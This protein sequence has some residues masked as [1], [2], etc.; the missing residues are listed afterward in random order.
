VERSDIS[1]VRTYCSLFIGWNGDLTQAEEHLRR[2]AFRFTEYVDNETPARQAM[3]ARLKSK[4]LG[5]TAKTLRH[6]W[7]ISSQGRV[8]QMKLEPHLLWVFR[9][10]DS[11]RKLAT[12]EEKGFR[13]TPTCF[14]ESS[15]FGGGPVITKK[16]SQL[17]QLHKIELAIDI[18]RAH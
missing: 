4:G 11:K 14:W 5:A 7:R 17:L 15:D 9:Q 6:N 10:F 16:V 2:F 12:L 13:I 1:T 3:L 18:Y 8:K